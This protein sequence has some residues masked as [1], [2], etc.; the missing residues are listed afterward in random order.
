MIRADA[1]G[2]SFVVSIAD[3]DGY[4]ASTDQSA[5]VQITNDDT[6]GVVIQSTGKLMASEGII[7]DA[8]AVVAGTFDISLLSQPINPVTITFTTDDADNA[9]M[10][11]KTGSTP[12]MRVTPPRASAPM[13]IHPSQFSLRRRIG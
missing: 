5:T 3:G 10:A 2:K 1:Q 8:D 11:L 7:G 12:V 6:A 13:R 9:S 4:T